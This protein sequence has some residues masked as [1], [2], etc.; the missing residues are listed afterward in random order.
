MLKKNSTYKL[1]KNSN[2]KTL[3][4]LGQ[5]F[6]TNEQVLDEIIYAAELTKSDVVLE[7]GTGLGVLTERLAHEANKV[8]TIEIDNRLIPI[9]DVVFFSY[10]NIILINEDILKIDL[11]NLLIEENL[12]DKPIKVIANLPYYITTPIIMKLLEEKINI[13]K[14][15]LM[16]QKE[17]AE[18]MNAEPST[19]SYGSLSVAVQYFCDTD[20]VTEVSKDSFYPKPNVDSCVLELRPRKNKKVEVY[21]EDIFF[22]LVKGSFV[23]R[24]KTIINSLTNYSD[25]VEKDKLLDVLEKSDI[26]S[27]R[28]GETLDINEFA[29]LA[30]NYYEMYIK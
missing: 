5:N 25:L 14:M 21:D 17:V 15:I 2:F 22:K 4:R 30:N 26:D 29:R 13:S 16:M 10:D 28:R 18:R 11:E 19:K 8:I 7:I 9:L 12:E 24:R 6:L 23:K 1:L 27:K 3:K 20:I